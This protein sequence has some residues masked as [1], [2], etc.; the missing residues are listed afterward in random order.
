MN[1]I[2]V[3]SELTTGKLKTMLSDKLIYNDVLSIVKF[4]NTKIIGKNIPNPETDSFIEAF[5]FKALGYKSVDDFTITTTTGK[6][7]EFS[8]IIITPVKV[9]NLHENFTLYQAPD[10][11]SKIFQGLLCDEF[12]RIKNRALY[13]LESN[14]DEKIV[15]MYALKNLQFIKTC[16]HN[17]KPV[18]H[19]LF[20]LHPDYLHNPDAFIHY[21]INFFLIRLRLFYEKFFVPFLPQSKKTEKQLLAE[22]FQ[23][24][25]NVLY[26]QNNQLTSN[27]N[28]DTS[29]KA[30]EPEN[31]Y[32]INNKKKI[33]PDFNTASSLPM[34]FELIAKEYNIS[35][36]ILK[37]ITPF[38]GK[39]QWNGNINSLGDVLFQ[40]M[41]EHKTKGKP[42]L[43]GPHEAIASFVSLF[44]V[45]KNGQPLSKASIKTCLQKSKTDKRPKSGSKGKIN[46]QFSKE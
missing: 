43:D 26:N 20:T 45:D 25:T 8:N 39:L 34:A 33:K 41:Y 30:S 15:K 2:I 36:E 29:L 31:D 46:L 21:N 4:V 27:D 22:L 9:Y 3:F 37:L 42:F 14:N 35:V 17:H 24:N 40:M 6:S 44:L 12:E 18:F 1:H 16:F 32:S 11:R 5:N 28:N 23:M 13:F 7:Q 38:I 10:K 19:E